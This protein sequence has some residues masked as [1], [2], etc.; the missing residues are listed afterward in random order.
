MTKLIWDQVGDR[1]FETGVDRGVLYPMN[2]SGVAWNG[3]TAV[4][5]S[6]SGGDGVPYYLDGIKYLN[7]PSSE[8]FT[9]KISAFTYPDEFYELDGVVFDSPGLGFGQQGRKPFGLSYRTKVGNDVDGYD[10]GYKLHLIYNA[11]AS[12]SS[13]SHASL[14]S[15]TEPT[16]FSWDITTTPISVEGHRPLSS[17]I[18]DSTKVSEYLLEAVEAMLYGK[19]DGEPNLP[20]PNDLVT[21][22]KGFIIFEVIDNLDGSFTATGMDSMFNFPSDTE[23]E[24]TSPSA[25]F[26]DAESYS[27]SSLSSSQEAGSNNTV[28]TAPQL[29]TASVGDASA[30]VLWTPPYSNGGTVITGYTVTASPGGMISNDGIFSG[31][32]NGVAYTFTVTATNSVGTSA[33]SAPSV[34]VTPSLPSAATVPNPPTNLYAMA[35]TSSATVIWDIPSNDGGSPITSFRISDTSGNHISNVGGST[36]SVVIPNLTNGVAYAFIVI[37]IN[38]VGNSV[39]SIASNLVTPTVEAMVPSKPINVVAVAGNTTATLSWALGY[40]GGS[41]ITELYVTDSSGVY[42]A[43]LSPATTTI[44]MAGLSNNTQ[45]SFTVT[46]TNQVGT[47]LPSSAVMVTPVAP[48]GNITSMLVPGIYGSGV[49]YDTKSNVPIGPDGQKQFVRF[50]ATSTSPLVSVRFTQ[51]TGSGYSGGNGGSTTVSIQGSDGAGHPNGT[52]IAQGSIAPGNPGTAEQYIAVPMSPAPSL[53]LGSI[54]YVVFENPSAVNYISVNNVYCWTSQSPLQPIFSNS[55]FGVGYSTGAWGSTDNGL[56]AVIDLSYSDGSHGGQA[57]YEAMLG[58]LGTINGPSKMVRE[59]FTVSGGSRTVSQASIRLHRTSGTDPIILTL[60]ASTGIGNGTVIDTATL[61]AASFAINTNP[62]ADQGPSSTWVTGNFS[63]SHV[64]TNGQTYNLRVSTASGS[65][66]TCVPM[67]SGSEN[68]Y[69]SYNFTDRSRG[70][71]EKTTNGSDY[72]LLYEYGIQDIAFTL[73]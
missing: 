66:Y 45:Y 5:E 70:G 60:E 34:S 13:R 11:L 46:A 44:I 37:A 67:R 42:N 63:S 33:P 36:T 65:T 40:N 62:T 57:Y 38:S 72:S 41:P 21:M 69:A 26:L 51:R 16:T 19:D 1:Y 3:L 71:G 7:T 61:P 53:T 64:L 58:F 18:I 59:Q 23:F 68:G 6:P 8:E 24:I 49:G 4:D 54:Y 30:I 15:S 31:L 55:E 35:G 25:V 43:V 28:P 17:L 14:T 9:A 27:L 50:K 52:K 20:T 48:V 12:P 22:F 32:T 2:A 47:S 73:T 29:V 39:V 56:T 10:H